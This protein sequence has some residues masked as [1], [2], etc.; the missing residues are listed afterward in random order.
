[1]RKQHMLRAVNIENKI[2]HNLRQNGKKKNV[3]KR[4]SDNLKGKEPK[5]NEGG[6]DAEI[7]KSIE[8]RKKHVLAR[9]RRRREVCFKKIKHPLHKNEKIEARFPLYLDKICACLSGERYYYEFNYSIWSKL[10]RE[11]NGLQ[12]NMIK[13]Q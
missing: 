2:K 13:T 11:Y 9:K 4:S 6:E 10:F 5:I 8:V 1:M 12:K 7:L 3:D